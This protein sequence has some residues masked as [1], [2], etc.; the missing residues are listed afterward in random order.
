[1][2]EHD[3]HMEVYATAILGTLQ[4]IANTLIEAAGAQNWVRPDTWANLVNGMSK[5]ST[6]ADKIT[7]LRNK[8]IAA[9]EPDVAEKY[10]K[11]YKD[12]EDM[13]RK[14]IHVIAIMRLGIDIEEEELAEGD[15]DLVVAW[16][17]VKCAS[18]RVLVTVDYRDD[19]CRLQT[20]QFPV[21]WLDLTK[22]QLAERKVGCQLV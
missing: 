3:K 5:I 4:I 19:K 22:K 7:E 9:E 11:L 10:L 17:V 14:C 12:S 6:E 21:A 18:G 15:L 2:T 8:V 1:M 13:R 16:S 20:Y